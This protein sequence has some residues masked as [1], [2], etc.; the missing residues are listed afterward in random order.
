M[1]FK[2]AQSTFCTVS[3]ALLVAGMGGIA[4][5]QSKPMTP[6]AQETPAPAASPS[7]GAAPNSQELKLSTQQVQEIQTIRA[8][9]LNQISEVLNPDQRQQ[10]SQG[11]KSGQGLNQVLLSM[12]L[13]NDQQTKI[14]SIVKT[15]NEQ[16]I[17]VLTPEQLQ[18]LRQESQTQ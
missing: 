5:A 7:P 2:L 16:L 6:S 13:T 3:V 9:A 15:T 17:K 11:L 18:Q 1:I 10:F 12:N 8:K 4:W 14:T